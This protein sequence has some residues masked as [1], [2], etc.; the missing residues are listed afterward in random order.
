MKSKIK[1]QCLKI[2]ILINANRF[3]MN[4]I[5]I[6]LVLMKNSDLTKEIWISC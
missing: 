1:I 3:L 4:K 6:E 2:L 5:K